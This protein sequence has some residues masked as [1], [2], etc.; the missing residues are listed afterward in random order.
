VF[1]PGRRWRADFAWPEHGL[2]VEVEGGTWLPGG[3]RHNRGRGFEDDCRK[4]LAAFLLGFRL[5]RFTTAMVDDLT[6]LKTLETYFRDG[7]NHFREC[8]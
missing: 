6:A 4:Y 1:Q 8:S 5:I 3:G 7:V 2:I